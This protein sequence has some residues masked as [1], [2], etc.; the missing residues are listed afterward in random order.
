LITLKNGKMA[1]KKIWVH[2]SYKRKLKKMAADAGLSMLE[3]TKQQDEIL[4]NERRKKK[5]FNFKI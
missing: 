4:S 3:Y 2:E 1:N 5:R